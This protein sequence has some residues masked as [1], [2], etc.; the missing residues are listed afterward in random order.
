MKVALLIFVII[1]HFFVNP[2]IFSQPDPPEEENGDK[3]KSLL[4][5]DDV[6]L[7]SIGIPIKKQ[8][9][10]F[11][12]KY[13]SG[14]N[15]CLLMNTFE[16]Q[17]YFFKLSTLKLNKLEQL[18]NVRKVIV[19]KEKNLIHLLQDDKLFDLDSSGELKTIVNL[20]KPIQKQ[21]SS[22][23]A[24]WS[25]ARKKRSSKHFDDYKGLALIDEFVFYVYKS[26]ILVYDAR[27]LRLIQA[28]N[29]N[30]K[31]GRRPSQAILP[32]EFRFL[33]DPID[34]SLSHILLNYKYFDGVYDGNNLYQKT[35]KLFTLDNEMISSQHFDR[36]DLIPR[37]FLPE[38]CIYSS[39]WPAEQYRDLP[40]KKP[41][42]D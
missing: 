39:N 4:D 10:H 1:G 3:I 24:K 2:S 11:E 27:N 5:A 9:S 32:L 35:W 18:K 19:D 6:W 12:K 13:F 8:S 38:D 15:T 34:K 17:F 33:I 30:N 23:R 14:E 7:P 41:T 21:A 40:G 20:A 36:I 28:I 37:G 29:I 16:Q 31:K 26:A 22:F 42:T 25:Q